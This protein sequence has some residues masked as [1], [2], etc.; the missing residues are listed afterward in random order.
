MSLNER[1]KK[2]VLMSIPAASIAARNARRRLLVVVCF[3][4]FCFWLFGAVPGYDPGR[5]LTRHHE[6]PKDRN[7]GL[8]LEFFA[9]FNKTDA[10]GVFLITKPA[11]E[12]GP[13]PAIYV[14]PFRLNCGGIV[15]R[16]H[17]IDKVK[18]DPRGGPV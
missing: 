18:P 6:R 4:I 10:G 9:D 12:T 16:E 3:M 13:R 11:F 2:S 14:D 5:G 17:L 15:D 1:V 7:T 8:F